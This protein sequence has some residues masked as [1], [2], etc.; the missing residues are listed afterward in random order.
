MLPF[1][2]IKTE[3]HEEFLIGDCNQQTQNQRKGFGPFL[4]KKLGNQWTF[5]CIKILKVYII[6]YGLTTFFTLIK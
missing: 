4:E 5:T 2:Q 3:N 6:H 1:N